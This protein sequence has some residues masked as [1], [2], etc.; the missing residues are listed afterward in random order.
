MKTKLLLTFLFLSFS[1]SAQYTFEELE[2]NSNG[3]SKPH[4]FVEFKGELYF[5]AINN[6]S[7]R[8]LWK[9]DGT[10]SGTVLVK[11]I[12]S[13]GDADPRRLTVLNNEL[14]FTAKNGTN[15]R[16]L[17]KTDGTEEG[18]VMVKDVLT[19][20]GDGLVSTYKPFHIHNNKLVFVGFLMNPNGGSFL[21]ESDGTENGT[22]RISSNVKVDFDT[23][24]E[25]GLVTLG[26]TLFFNGNSNGGANVGE[27][28]WKYDGTNTTIVK[29]I[30]PGSN[31]SFPSEMT[32]YNNLVYFVAEKSGEGDELWK[33]DGTESGTTLVKDIRPGGI[34]S[35]SNY[36]R[37]KVFKNKLYFAANDGVHGREIWV[38]DGT[39]SGT[40]LF[41]DINT[42]GNQ[43]ALVES[44]GV[45][46]LFY[47]FNDKM[48]FKATDTYNASNIE[49]NIEPWETDGTIAGTK[50][51]ANLNPNG[52]SMSAY[53]YFFSYNNR[54]L[55][56]GID[57]SDPT[58]G[59]LWSYD[60]FNTPINIKPENTTFEDVEVGFY[61]PIVFNNTLYLSA[62]FN[63]NNTDNGTELW[64]I[65]SNPLN[66]QR[67]QNDLS[68]KV[69]PNPTSTN[70][71]IFSE[72]KSIEKIELFN[73]LGKKVFEKRIENQV[74]VNLNSREFSKGMYL[75]KIY[76]E[77]KITSK[78]LII[79]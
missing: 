24:T 21:F 9:T 41:L 59:T 45:Q 54:L 27:E 28:L 8:E 32:V 68:F 11:D 6:N 29:D 17:W 2:I 23:N 60:F 30:N 53:N 1:L 22:K 62:K 33:T 65:T 40:T 72:N 19:G 37:F 76:S 61:R 69:Y 36:A 20:V 43:N 42:N 3:D 70:F 16:E 34:G 63:I 57:F 48:Y 13:N 52:N 56:T 74:K 25:K 7:G 35:F 31:S 78:K 77:N 75:V 15:G 73:V 4:S 39:E 46:Q 44:D 38:S 14:F 47:I 64:K 5:S 71:T 18:T 12:N 58:K 26:N 10:T 79:N 55:F 49:N 67:F 50:Q 51:L 66:V